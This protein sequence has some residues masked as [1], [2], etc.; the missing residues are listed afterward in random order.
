VTEAGTLQLE[1]LPLDGAQRWKVE[2]EVR[3]DSA[4]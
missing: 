2:F 3:G 4:P 1:A